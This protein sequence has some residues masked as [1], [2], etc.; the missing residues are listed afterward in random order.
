MRISVDE[1]NRAVEKTSKKFGDLI[2]KH[3]ASLKGIGKNVTGK[4]RPSGGG[5]LAEK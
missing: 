3:I 4:Q 1:K 2:E 5:S